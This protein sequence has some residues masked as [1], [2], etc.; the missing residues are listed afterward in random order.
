MKK[1]KIKFGSYV[2][3]A[4]LVVFVS[5]SFAQVKPKTLRVSCLNETIGLPSRKLTQLPIHPA[6]NVGTDFRVKTGKHWQRS[7]GT[8]FYYYY[9]QAFEHSLM[10]DATY[11]LGYKF[12]FG[13]QLNLTTAA[14]YKHA[15]LTGIKYTVIDGE[16][17]PTSHFGKA[18]FNTKLGLGLEYPFSEK[19]TLTTDYKTMAVAPFG[20]RILPISINTF[21]GAGLKINLKK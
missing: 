8:D 12:P 19:Y 2:A 16:Y 20:D 13:L 21:L 15:I 11:R 18:Q 4:L 14:G 9:Q 1:A 17:Q 5:A 10:L 3:A 7:L 6:I